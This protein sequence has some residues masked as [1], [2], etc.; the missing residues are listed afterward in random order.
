MIASPHPP[1]RQVQVLRLRLS[2]Y[3]R[4]AHVFSISPY[5][6]KARISVYFRAYAARHFVGSD[7]V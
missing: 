3:Q 6:T 5:S 4:S 2:F 7:L 1:T